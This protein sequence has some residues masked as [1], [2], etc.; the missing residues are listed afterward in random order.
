MGAAALALLLVAQVAEPR[1]PVGAPGWE[2]RGDPVAHRVSSLLMGSGMHRGFVTVVPL[3]ARIPSE[4]GHGRKDAPAW[5]SH[6]TPGRRLQE[7]GQHYLR[8][9]NNSPRPVF[10]GA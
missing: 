1:S 6:S 5:P 9:L 7:S 8:A 2:K 4:A 10:V 3:F